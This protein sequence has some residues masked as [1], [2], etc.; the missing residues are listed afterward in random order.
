MDNEIFQAFIILT[1]IS[2]TVLQTFDSYPEPTYIYTINTICNTF[3][4]VFIVEMLINLVGIGFERYFIDPYNIFDC[5]IVITSIVDIIVS[6]VIVMELNVD[7]ITALR[8][9]RLIRIFKLGKN[10]RQLG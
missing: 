7:F 5:I 8:T 3:S 4:F 9:F 1:I 2:N 6:Y 10:W